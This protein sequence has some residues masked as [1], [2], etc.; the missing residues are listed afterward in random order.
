MA[1]ELNLNTHSLV[2]A[3]IYNVRLCT[4]F[5][6][7]FYRDFKQIWISSEKIVFHID[8][9]KM[10]INRSE[11]SNAGVSCMTRN[12]KPWPTT[13][14]RANEPI[15]DWYKDSIKDAE[16][17]KRQSRCEPETKAITLPKSFVNELVLYGKNQDEL[18]LRLQNCLKQ[19]QELRLF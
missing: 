18:E 9:E 17:Q 2:E 5:I 3:E 10:Y 8:G 14:P 12:I 6:H 1:N 15:P 4:D 19:T 11:K 16:R 7:E 13:G